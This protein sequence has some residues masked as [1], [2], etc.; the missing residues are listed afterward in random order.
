MKRSSV[1]TKKKQNPCS[2]GRPIE[3][4]KT[5]I[6]DVAEALFAERGYKGATIREIAKQ[7]KCNIALVSYH[8]GGKDGLY[9][10]LFLRHLKRIQE[11]T[12]PT[13]SAALKKNWP[14]L[15]SEVQREF[16]ALLYGFAG[17]NLLRPQMGMIIFREMM[18]GGKFML[19]AIS[20]SQQNFGLTLLKRL[21]KLQKQDVIRQDLD[22]RFGVIAALGP[23]VYSCIA[24]PLLKDLYGFNQID[25]NYVRSLCLHTTRTFF[26][27][28]TQR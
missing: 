15:H 20:K 19:S 11:R 4:D 12:E 16:V 2:P 5:I 13:D 18:T 10:A 22:L 14:E 17:L 24:R 21:T 8:F 27:G 7:A 1:R 9:E 3:T 23:L 25:E 26:E 28:W 6:L